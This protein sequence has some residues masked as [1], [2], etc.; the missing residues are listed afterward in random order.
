MPT[1]AKFMA[2]P[3]PIVPEPMSAADLISR[4]AVS[5]GTSGILVTC[6]SAKNRCRMAFDSV[7]SRSRSNSSRSRARP[8][9]NGSVTAASRQSTIASGAG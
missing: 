2:M 5:S 8:L 9:A 1:L 4:V 3:P 6:R 7:V